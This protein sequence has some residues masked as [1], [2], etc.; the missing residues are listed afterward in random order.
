VRE[1]ERFRG[2]N[3]QLQQDL[4]KKDL[5][6]K[7]WIGRYEELIKE[8]HRLRGRSYSAE[9]PREFERIIRRNNELEQTVRVLEGELLD[10]RR[11]RDN[12]TVAE[13][14]AA[15]WRQKYQEFK[16]MAFE[17]QQGQGQG[18]SAPYDISAA[19][20]VEKSTKK[21]IAFSELENV[22]KENLNL[23]VRVKELEQLSASAK[24]STL[25]ATS[26]END[27][28]KARY[29][30][31]LEM[32]SSKVA[33]KFIPSGSILTER[34]KTFE[35]LLEE[36]TRLKEELKKLGQSK[37][38]LSS[39][40]KLLEEIEAELVMWKGHCKEAAPQILSSCIEENKALVEKIKNLEK[41]SQLRQTT[42]E[43]IKILNEE[44]S[45]WKETCSKIMKDDQKISK[46]FLD[47][48]AQLKAEKKETERER[49]KNDDLQLIL[50]TRA[51]EVNGT[52]KR[53]IYKT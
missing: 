20:H 26:S 10:T 34:Q 38:A 9:D 25:A 2:Q 40:E 41:E 43:D 35:N 51:R 52:K 27:K 15:A 14:E 50:E 30:T 44:V 7:D 48:F 31:L 1:L 12:L 16:L 49:V 29:E 11:L 21:S 6:N 24:N 45:Y 47:E 4:A 37:V 33:G 17:P 46:N 32:I 18:Y 3:E 39:L 22:Q 5:E 53:P 19:E 8:I 13:N 42:A 36:N 23:R 28:W